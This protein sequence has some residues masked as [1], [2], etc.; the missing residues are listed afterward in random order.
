[1]NRN[2]DNNFDDELMAKAAKLATP[3]APKRDL[4]PDIGQAI[5]A[6]VV[7]ERTVWNTVWAQA[8]AVIL[9][10]GGSAGLTYMA[11][12]G[13][14]D[15]TVP[16]IDTQMQLVFEPV[17]GSFGSQYF[18]GPGYQDAHRVVADNLSVRLDELSPEARA[19]VL[20]NIETIRKAIDDINRALAENPGNVLLQ[21]L[22][23]DT[24]RD[25]LSVMKK[26]DTIS[27][28]AMYR[29]DI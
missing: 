26:V 11:M 17:S 1:M 5:T 6:Q 13:D 12:S 10:V 27:N 4:W 7:R 3:V 21:E 15:S 28:N 8:A 24:Y 20:A 2:D 14:G 18:L 19:D 9:L 22:L 23:I 29:S 16:V 25:E